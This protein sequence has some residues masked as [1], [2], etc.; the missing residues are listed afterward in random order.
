MSLIVKNYGWYNSDD[1]VIMESTGKWLKSS[2]SSILDILFPTCS[3]AQNDIVNTYIYSTNTHGNKRSD[4]AQVMKDCKPQYNL[5]MQSVI[6]GCSW[7]F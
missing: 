2:Q 3:L 4:T 6:N 7:K 5:V 1:G